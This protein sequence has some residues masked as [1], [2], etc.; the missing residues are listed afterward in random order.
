MSESC[1]SVTWLIDMCCSTH[2]YVCDMALWEYLH[3]LMSLEYDMT[4]W[5]RSLMS[6]ECDMTHLYMWMWCMHIWTS[7]ATHMN[8]SF[9]CVI[10]VWFHMCC[11]TSIIHMCCICVTNVMYAHMNE[12]CNTCEWVTSLMWYDYLRVPSSFIWVRHEWVMSQCVMSESCHSVTQHIHM[13]CMTH[14]YVR[15]KALWG[16]LHTCN[17]IC[18]VTLWHDSLMS[19]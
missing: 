7:H 16:F 11:M 19:H 6:H 9:I 12:S 1:H 5:E 14:S 15:D 4:L 8:D 13:C 2:S 3:S 10:F 18:H 17:H